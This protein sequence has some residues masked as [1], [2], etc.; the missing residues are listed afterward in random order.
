MKEKKVKLSNAPTLLTFKESAAKAGSKGT[1]LF[2]HGLKAKKEGN[3]KEYESLAEKGFLVAGIDNVGHGERAYPDFDS[4]AKSWGEFEV[5]F[6]QMV[7]ECALEIPRLIDN[8]I[9][10]YG[11]DSNKIGVCGISMGGYIAYSAILSD[12][13]IKVAT[14]ILG[15]PTSKSNLVENPKNFPEK[16]YPTALL[17]QNAGQDTSVNPKFAREFHKKL[18]PYYE[19]A[20]ERLKYIE[21]PDSGHFM[22]EK[23]W[24]ELWENVVNWFVN[25]LV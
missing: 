10:S 3:R 18:R 16:F 12:S 13:R 17:S 7:R 5:F 2:Y 19:K 14:P 1:I 24:D 15:S 6:S 8:L 9:E 21:Y 11:I 22:V 25:F 20:P 23:D 4:M